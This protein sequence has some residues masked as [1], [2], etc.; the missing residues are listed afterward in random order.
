VQKLTDLLNPANGNNELIAKLQSLTIEDSAQ[1]ISSALAN[2]ASPVSKA[3]S[4]IINDSFHN[5]F[6]EYANRHSLLGEVSK[7]SLSSNETAAEITGGQLLRVEG[8]G[9]VNNPHGIAAIPEVVLTAMTG[10]LSA[11]EKAVSD[12]IVVT[13]SDTANHKVVIELVG[14]TDL[15]LTAYTHG[16]WYHL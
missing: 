15:S 13:I 4:I 6:A 9:S 10:S 8:L 2:N 12:G 11:T 3:D 1:A 14:V 5:V 16:G 7:L